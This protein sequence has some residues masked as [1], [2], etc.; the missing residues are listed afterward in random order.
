[1]A[2]LDYPLSRVVVTED[3][4]EFN[5]KGYNVFFKFIL[6]FDHNIIAGNDVLVVDSSDR[7]CAVGKA[8]VSGTEMKYYKDG[9]AVK[10]HRGIK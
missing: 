7:L 10:V 3:S 8:T 2:M 4:A 6:D 5:S 1:M 9:I